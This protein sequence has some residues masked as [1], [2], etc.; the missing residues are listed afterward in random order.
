[1]AKP[2][3]WSGD[4]KIP[5]VIS[6]PGLRIRVKVVTPKDIEPLGEDYGQWIYA[7]PNAETPYATILING[8][9]PI[10][11]QRY[12]LWHELQHSVVE[13]LDQMVEKFPIHV[14]THAMA[15]MAMA[16]HEAEEKLANLE[17]VPAPKIS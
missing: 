5:R 12:I 16:L 13:G 6:L 7:P 14:H 3:V 15:K 1:M 17:K 11:L 9:W 4:W 8:K 10:E 2:P